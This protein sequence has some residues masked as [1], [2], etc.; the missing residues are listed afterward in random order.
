MMLFGLMGLGFGRLGAGG[1]HAALLAAPATP[2]LALISG[3]SDNTPNF[4]LDGDLAVN[5]VVRFQYSTDS[6]FAGASTI[7]NTIDAGE[8]AANEIAFATGTLADGT[9]YFRARIERPGHAVSAWSNTQTE[10]INTAASIAFVNAA[11][12][13]YNGGSGPLTF[14]YSVGVGTNRLLVVPVAADDVSDNITGVTY[15]GV[16]MTLAGKIAP[17]GASQRWVYLFYL[18]NPASGANNVVVSTSGTV[19]LAGAADYTGVKQSAQPDA[20]TTNGG[21]AITSI[22]GTLTTTADKCWTILCEQ[23]TFDNLPAEAL[24]GATRRTF[25]ASFG[26]WTLFDSNAAVTPAGST[27]MVVTTHNSPGT[28]ETIVMASFAPS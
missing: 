22:T 15:S 21:T 7:T 14:S 27:S 5:D 26:S 3:T 25:E 1:R 9:W 8:D 20:T 2:T 12:G 18:L 10:T 16:A 17:A 4:T 19:V 11:D 6:G 24:S 13:G 28:A 23:H